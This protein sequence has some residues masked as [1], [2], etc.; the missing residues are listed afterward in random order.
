[1]HYHSAS[2]KNTISA[3]YPLPLGGE[4]LNAASSLSSTLRL[5]YM[6]TIDNVEEAAASVALLFGESS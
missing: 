6:E 3:L 2:G 1:M 5:Q 4:T